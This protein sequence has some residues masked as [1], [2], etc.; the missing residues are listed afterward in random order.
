MSLTINDHHKQQ[1]F[2]QHV[3]QARLPLQNHLS[4]AY[5]FIR[6]PA[7]DKAIV[8]SNGRV[9]SY[10]KYQETIHDFYCQGYSVFVLDHIGQG[11]SSRLTRNPHK[12]HI[13]SF[14]RYVEHFEFFMDKVVKPQAPTQLYLLGHSMG[15]AIATLYLA[16]HPATFNAA[17]CCAPMYGIKLPLPRG[18]ILWLAKKLNAFPRS[19]E[20]NYIIGG[21]DYQPAAFAKNPLTHSPKRYQQLLELYQDFPQI[22]LGSPTYQWL[23]EGLHASEQARQAAA[24]NTQIPLLILQAG[25]DQI[26][27]NHA[28]THATSSMTQLEVIPG[29]RHEILIEDDCYREIAMNKILAFFAQHTRVPA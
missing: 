25:N 14:S 7:S 15:S 27:D 9:E 26:V 20:P 17:V 4:L 12:G 13:D 3:T 2:W 29:A 18:F 1:P 16:R 8:I 19:A 10:L 22:Q 28:Q 11:L 23:I 6:H 24:A 21:T 5:C